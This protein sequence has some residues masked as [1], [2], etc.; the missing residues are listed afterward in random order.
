[1]TNKHSIHL[2][3]PWPETKEKIKEAN[4]ELTDADL[5]YSPGKEDE[6]LAH[7]S[8]K[9]KMNQDDVKSWIESISSNKGKA[10]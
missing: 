7:L 10:S 4:I 3:V 2:A 8:Q 1:M 5:D 6:L 9:M